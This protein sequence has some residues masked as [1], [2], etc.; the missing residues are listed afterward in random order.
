MKIPDMV[1]TNYVK[2]VHTAPNT[3]ECEYAGAE[4]VCTSTVTSY[5]LVK[6][7]LNTIWTIIHKYITS[8]ILLACFC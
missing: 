3:G 6:L 7:F 5:H 2:C 1:N 4:F 8:H